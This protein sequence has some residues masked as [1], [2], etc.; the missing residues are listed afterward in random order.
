[1][2][3]KAGTGLKGEGGEG[4]FETFLRSLLPSLVG[5]YASG[6]ELQHGWAAD[7]LESDW[8]LCW[9]ERLLLL[10]LLLWL[11][12]TQTIAILTCTHFPDTGIYRND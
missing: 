1:M 6:N 4:E 5:V 12:N 9:P 8:C 3:G 11:S 10:P 2:G 7:W